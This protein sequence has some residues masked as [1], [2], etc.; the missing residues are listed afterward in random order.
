MVENRGQS[1]K[2]TKEMRGTPRGRRG[3]RRLFWK[4]LK[5]SGH[6]ILKDQGREE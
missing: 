5:R 3:R 4:S 6:F 2:A 1:G